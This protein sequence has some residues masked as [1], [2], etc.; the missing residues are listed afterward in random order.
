VKAWRGSAS[1]FLQNSDLDWRYNALNF[2]KKRANQVINRWK[3]M[4]KKRDI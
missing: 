1:L 4:K 2:V 3:N